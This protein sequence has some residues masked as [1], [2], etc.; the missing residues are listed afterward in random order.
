MTPEINATPL[1]WTSQ[2][3][4]QPP[5]RTPPLKG[6]KIVLPPIAL[7]QL[8]SAATTNIQTHSQA[9]APDFDPYNPYSVAAQRRALEASFERQQ[10]LPHPLTFRLV[11]PINGRVVFAGIREFSAQDNEI[12][13]SPFLRESLGIQQNNV[14]ASNL[15]NGNQE[16]THDEPLER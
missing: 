15:S 14:E 4:V 16:T 6:D 10:N 13:I 9:H 3:S 2:F 11:N 8:L 1:K 12:G 5:S 7:E